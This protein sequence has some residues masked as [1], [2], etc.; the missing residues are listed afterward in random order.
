VTRYLFATVVI[1]LVTL[2][3]AGPDLDSMWRTPLGEKVN[4]LPALADLDADGHVDVVALTRG[5]HLLVLSGTTGTILANLS[6][7][8]SGAVAVT[9]AVFEG[10]D[11]PVIVVGTRDGT[12]ALVRTDGTGNRTLLAMGSSYLNVTNL[13]P[14]SSGSVIP[15][16]VD[17]DGDGRAELFAVYDGGLLVRTGVDG[18]LGWAF[19]AGDDI[20][21]LPAVDDVDGDGAGELVFGSMDGNVYCLDGDGTLRWSRAL[22]EW[23]TGA[24]LLLDLDGDSL[25]EIIVGDQ[26]GM[27]HA[28]DGAG[29]VLWSTPTDGHIDH[30]PVA[31]DGGERIAAVSATTLVLLDRT[32]AVVRSVPLGAAVLGGPVSADVVGDQDDEV[33]VPVLGGLSLIGKDGGPDRL[34]HTLSTSLV[35]TDLDGDGM[36][37]LLTGLEDGTIVAW[38]TRSG[39]GPVPAAA[40]R[41]DQ[42]APASPVAPGAL[43]SSSAFV[44]LV[45]VVLLMALNRMSHQAR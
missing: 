31:L 20:L 35:L 2:V 21:S 26:A 44:A 36:V 41:A 25:Q 14:F 16:E 9:A 19:Q 39:E 7:E 42:T 29:E 13:I 3:S 10:E 24:P 33:L 23:I 43:M 6:L 40:V 37:E 27:V 17:L 12:L 5:E 22:G 30:G 8:D 45:L 1:L 38:R 28:L 18:S 32:G 4:A 11:A 15:A 34:D